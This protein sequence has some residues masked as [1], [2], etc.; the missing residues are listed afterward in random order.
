MSSLEGSRGSSWLCTRLANVSTPM[1]PV[2]SGSSCG[3]RY[4]ASP[5]R[6]DCGSLIGWG[7][8]LV[9]LTLASSPV[10]SCT[11]P[12]HQHLTLRGRLQSAPTLYPTLCGCPV[13]CRHPCPHLSVAQPTLSH[14]VISRRQQPASQEATKLNTRA[15]LAPASSSSSR[16]PSLLGVGLYHTGYP[17]LGNPALSLGLPALTRHPESSRHPAPSRTQHHR[18]SHTMG[19]PTLSHSWR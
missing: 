15:A 11:T 12:Q 13:P 7:H 19:Y 4:R 9:A 3:A 1:K 6:Q 10:A 5:R 8:L 18:A 2:F 14:S 17:V 16:V